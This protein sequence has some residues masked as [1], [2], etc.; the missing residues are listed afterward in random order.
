MFLKDS[1]IDL[2]YFRPLEISVEGKKQGVTK[3]YKNKK[4][5]RLLIC[6]KELLTSFI[7]LS[8]NLNILNDNFQLLCYKEIKNRCE[9]A[10][11]WNLVKLQIFCTWTKKDKNLL[12]FMFE[13]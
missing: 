1:K 12:N 8:S 4:E 2:F 5:G 11:V 10:T 7:E 3:K 9:Y 6:K 13:K